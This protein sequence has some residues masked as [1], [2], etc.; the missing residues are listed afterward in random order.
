MDFETYSPILNIGGLFF[1]FNFYFA[2]FF[3]AAILIVSIKFLDRLNPKL[4]DSY[5]D[6]KQ[7]V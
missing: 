1:A 6:T 4:K 5:K 7:E 2:I 3:Y